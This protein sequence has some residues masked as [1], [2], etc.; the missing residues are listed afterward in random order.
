MGLL[1][2]APLFVESL[3]RL[4]DD[5]T[6]FAR[7]SLPTPAGWQRADQ[8]TWV[9]LRPADA[10]L[11]Q[12]GW[13]IHASATAENAERV[14][15]TVWEYCVERK[16]AFKFLRSGTILKHVN[17]KSAARSAGGKLV[18]IYPVDDKVL[19]LTLT[20]L[21]LLLR[22]VT[23][24]YILNDLR[25]G[26]GP[27]YLRFGA[28]QQRYCFSPTGDY[29]P[30]V[31]RPDGVLVPDLR[32]PVFKVPSWAE[33]PGFVQA[34][35]D[36]ARTD[37]TGT[38]PYRVEKA[39]QFSNGG[40]VY[41]A[42]ETGSGRTVLLREAR[43]HAGLDLHGMDAVSRLKRE[44]AMLE[45]LDKLDC[46]PSTFGLIRHWEHSF[47]VEEFID[48]EPL[49]EAIGR[50]HPL[51]RPGPTAAEFAEYSEWA[52]VTFARIEAAVA[53]LHERGIVFGDLKPGNI[54]IRPD[55]KVCLVDFET[56]AAVGDDVQ[57]ALVTEGFSASWARDGYAADDYA[58]ACIRLALFV[59]LTEL[60]RFT[61]GKHQQLIALA[62][63]RF[64]VPPEFG[65]RLRTQLAP[66]DLEPHGPVPDWPADP[67]ADGWRE[68]LD[69]L[70]AA[71]VGSATPSRKDRLFPGDLRQFEHQEASLGFGAAG[72]LHALHITGRSGYPEFTEHVDW[73]VRASR[74]VQWPRPG[75]YDG[76]AGTAYVLDELGQRQEALEALAR[77]RTFD[78]GHCGPGLFGGLAG[79]G[80][81]LLHFGE[82]AAGIGGELVRRLSIDAAPTG[83]MH[84]WSGP[85]LL[86]T[87]LFEATGDP[88]WLRH[89]E[90]ALARDIGRCGVPSGRRVQVRDGQRW[91]TG[92]ERGSA[93]IG[94][95]VH[96][97]LRSRENPHLTGVRDR[98]RDGLDTEL[99]LAGG[100][101]SGQAGVLYGCAHL[102]ASP[103]LH[104][105]SLGVHA[106]R[107]QGHPAFALDGRLRLSMDLAT[108]TAGVLLAVHTALTGRSEGAL[109]FLSTTP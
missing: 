108:G 29:V 43:P 25:W 104:L 96:E 107:Y 89:A 88:Q 33:V 87:R 65:P 10:L 34:Q 98:I 80:L 24:P 54:M 13:K 53:E 3:E 69:G 95:A 41:R 61:P 79:I 77:L 51:L 49:Y 44:H 60:L 31:A 92:L 68:L 8:G 14:V 27:L 105:R 9:N 19:E 102:G 22:S 15:D 32:G 106:V 74:R 12:Q 28:F 64:T 58:L 56:A 20:E 46:V 62:E 101:F 47:L 57:P 40:G 16:I 109:P 4:D 81:A 72:V 85:A 67:A 23:G 37:G 55:G 36:A 42:K 70:R 94:I 91:Q 59:P 71:V 21:S 45:R 100:L 90:T 1:V 78:L 2:A 82:D 6:W 84:G 48:G 39:L 5:S 50:R 86:F 18:T 83:L 63:D 76:L 30:A 73:L 66:P 97:Y 75:L 11:P 35:I 38:F 52:H 17:S 26:Q 99:L 93:G 103:A 7:S